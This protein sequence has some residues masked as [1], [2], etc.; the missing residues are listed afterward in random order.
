[1]EV[2]RHSESILAPYLTGKVMKK[3]IRTGVFLPL[4]VSVMAHSTIFNEADVSSMLPNEN[5]HEVSLFE[6]SQSSAWLIETYVD[7][8]EPSLKYMMKTS[9]VG[10]NNGSLLTDSRQLA[11][12]DLTGLLALSEGDT[13]VFAGGGVAPESG[14]WILYNIENCQVD[15]CEIL[16]TY[17]IFLGSNGYP[18][19]LYG[20]LPVEEISTPKCEVDAAASLTF[21]DDGIFRHLGCGEYAKYSYLFVEEDEFESSPHWDENKQLNGIKSAFFVGAGVSHLLYAESENDVPYLSIAKH[22]LIGNFIGLSEEMYLSDDLAQC[23]QVFLKEDWGVSCLK[24]AEDSTSIVVWSLND[25]G[26]WVQTFERVHDVPV[27]SFTLGY[28]SEH[29]FSFEKSDDTLLIVNQDKEG[30]VFTRREVE[31][32][33]ISTNAISNNQYVLMVN[34]YID[35][36]ENSRYKLVMFDAL[37]TDQNPY[38]KKGIVTSIPTLYELSTTVEVEDEKTLPKDL[39]VE[40]SVKPKWIEFDNETL[41]LVGMPSNEDVG[42]WPITLKVTDNAGQIAELESEILVTLQ[43]AQV[44]I[45]EPTLFERL[46]IDEPVPFYEL[47][48]Q[49]SPIQVFEDALFEAKITIEYRELGDVELV[50]ESLPNWLTY[51]AETML[52]SGLPE[53]S[54]VGVSDEISATVYD[55]YNED[56]DRYPVIKMKFQVIEVDEPFQVLS[57]GSDSLYVGDKYYYQL[58]VKDEESNIE[59]FTVTPGPLPSWV[60]FDKETSSLSGVPEK[61]D[62]GTHR[63]QMILQDEVGHTVI[64]TFD[65]V[66][67]KTVT[68][69]EGGSFSFGLIA[70]ISLFVIR[71]KKVFL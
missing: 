2:N 59:D 23:Q 41:D 8:S 17:R 68:E 57:D 18:D 19:S 49:L 53:Q 65:I 69:K 10:R 9:E 47:A 39:D 58:E 12:V 48:Q 4:F 40:I 32:T 66:V 52:L 45:F 21:N 64:H 13:P 11:S 55:K 44:N 37:S 31:S 16:R 51:D 24:L 6:R 29:V 35:E 26:E 1:M 46:E 43:S 22:D 20:Q 56:E 7:E 34:S 36:W 67:K 15:S 71:R 33:E 5:A 28:N 61:S 14:S 27:N 25:N 50:F 63:V 3:T 60:S 30:N 70:L 62:I 42:N 38:F 54:N